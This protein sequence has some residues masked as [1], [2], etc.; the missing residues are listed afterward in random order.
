MRPFNFKMVLNNVS[1]SKHIQLTKHNVFFIFSML[2]QIVSNTVREHA[3]E[4]LFS[5][6]SLHFQI[7][8]NTGRMRAI[9]DVYT[10]LVL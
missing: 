9:R 2:F 10:S 8:L 5:K 6:C 7:V 1:Q 3:F 4:T